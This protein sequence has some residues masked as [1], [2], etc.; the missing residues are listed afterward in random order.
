MRMCANCDN[1]ESHDNT[2]RALPPL[3]IKRIENNFPG[4]GGGSPG[5]WPAVKPDEWCAQF[6][7]RDIRAVAVR[8][9]R[10]SIED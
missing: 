1:Y 2:C 7:R 9:G 3:I 8:V 6:Q 10:P 4:D 5:R